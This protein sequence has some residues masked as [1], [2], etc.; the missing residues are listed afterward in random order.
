MHYDK[1]SKLFYYNNKKLGELLAALGFIK[2]EPDR[3]L[4]KRK[5]D[6]EKPLLNKK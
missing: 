2:T 1:Q 6:R 5:I 4:R 3:Q